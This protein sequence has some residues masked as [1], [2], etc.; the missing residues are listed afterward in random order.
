MSKSEKL[1]KNS[2][3]LKR[4]EDGDVGIKKPSEADAENMGVAGDTNENSPGEMP[5]NVHQAAERHD[6]HHKHVHE[7]L[8]MHGRHEQE[9]MTGKE[10]KGNMHKKHETEMKDMHGRH[11]E[12]MK[13]LHKRHNVS[14]EPKE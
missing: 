11:Q 5:I 10:E 8:Q 7:H 2:P 1:Y 3:S 6:M 12:E 4:G 13:S 9:H 14:T